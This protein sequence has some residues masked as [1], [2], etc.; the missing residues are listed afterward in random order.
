METPS[1]SDRADE[2]AS[3]SLTQPKWE[4][5]VEAAEDEAEGGPGDRRQWRAGTVDGR[6]APGNRE[7][8]TGRG[9]GTRCG[10]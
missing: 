10:E 9:R 5:I 3:V 6:S 4:N 8:A 7:H 1:S 2:S